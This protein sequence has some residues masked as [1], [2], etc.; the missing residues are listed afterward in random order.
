M[1]Q[2][3]AGQIGP[4]RWAG[5]EW[6]R[7]IGGKVLAEQLRAASKPAPVSWKEALAEP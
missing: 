7:H 4:Q 1:N 3:I 5:P 6:I 2:Q